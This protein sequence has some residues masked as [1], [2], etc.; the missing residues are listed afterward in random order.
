M[1]SRMD[2]DI[3]RLMSLLKRKGIDD[4]TLVIFTSDNGPAHERRSTSNSSTAPPASAAS[5][6]TLYEGGIRVPIIARWPGHITPGSTSDTPLAF[7]DF[8]PTLAELAGAQSPKNIDGLSFT[9]TLLAKGPQPQHDYLYWEFP[10]KIGQQALRQGDFKAVRTKTH[11]N[12]TAPVELY[13]L[14]SD[15]AES[16]NVAADHPEIATH[17][18]QLMQTARTESD[19]F[20]L[21]NRRKTPE[22]KE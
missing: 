11:A 19:E 10:A 16:N 18:T 1:I 17:L 6:K 12:P 15:P 14:K 2:R 5:R 9:P 7:W 22:P 20:P 3:G 4:N 8:L 21:F 13:N